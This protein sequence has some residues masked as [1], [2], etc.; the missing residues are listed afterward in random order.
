MR[1]LYF[2]IRREIL[3]LVRDK[4][5][6]SILFLMPLLLIIVITLTQQNAIN[7]VSG[8]EIEILFINHDGGTIGNLMQQGFSESNEIKLVERYNNKPL[9]DS[10]LKALT[11]KGKFRAGIIISANT[12]ED[13][14]E[15][16]ISGMRSLIEGDEDALAKEKVPGIQIVF[17][18]ALREMVKTSIMN[19]VKL[20][21]RGAESRLM[22]QV[23]FNQLSEVIVTEDSTSQLILDAL[24]EIRADELPQEIVETDTSYGN[25]SSAIVRPSITQNNVPAFALFAMFFIVIPLAGSLIAEKN[26]GTYDRLKTLPV[27]YINILL[28]KTLAY[29]L[30]CFLQFLLMVL[31]GIYVFPHWLG[32]PALVTGNHYFAIFAATLVSALSAIGFGLLV[33]TYSTT[34]NQAA[35]FGAILVVIMAALGG[36]FMPVNMMPDDLKL[37]SNLSPLRWGIDAFL[38]LFARG[39]GLAGIWKN[40]LLLFAFFCISLGIAAKRF[41]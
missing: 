32:L 35:M 6:L 28:G 23:L 29:L 30:V 7:S 4:A 1:K 14:E 2:N 3:T 9:T 18:P 38:D 19:A 10:M 22:T 15:K 8:S 31:V 36:I 40:L 13:A 5:G 39:A 33:G 37:I 34:H 12:T 21:E 16:I 41:G 27:S 20:T 17:D 24:K 26:E 25:G 11:A